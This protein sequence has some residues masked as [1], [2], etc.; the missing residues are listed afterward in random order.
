MQCGVRG[1]EY[2]VQD[3]RGLAEP[4]TPN[5][6]LRLA[7]TQMNWSLQ[8]CRSRGQMSIECLRPA[9]FGEV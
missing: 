5:P 4:Q 3:L 7:I 2:G 8:R 1:V 6:T 9:E